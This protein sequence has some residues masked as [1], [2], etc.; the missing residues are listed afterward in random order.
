MKSY[1]WQERDNGLQRGWSA[2]QCANCP[3]TWVGLSASQQAQDD[4][5]PKLSV[6]LEGTYPGK[7]GVPELRRL[8]ITS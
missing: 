2:R 8:L 5:H 4:P 1:E 7:L 3:Q 6:G